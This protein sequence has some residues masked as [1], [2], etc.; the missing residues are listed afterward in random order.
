MR[1]R[2]P[3]DPHIDTPPDLLLIGAS[4]RAL[5]ASVRRSGFRGAL[6]ALDLFGDLDQEALCRSLVPGRD[7][8][9]G[10]NIASLLHAAIALRPRAVMFS[11]GVENHPRLLYRLERRTTILGNSARC[12]RLVRTP[13]RFFGCLDAAGIPHPRVWIESRA[14]RRI[15]DEVRTLA[16]AGG[17]LWKPCLGG[18]G[19]RIRAVA[20]AR[21]VLDT[22]RGGYLQERVDGIPASVSFVA[23]GR[24]C[25]FLGYC[26]GLVGEPGLG[27]GGFLYAG[28]LWGPHAAWLP[29]AARETLARAARHLTRE[30]GLRGLNGI[31]FI[32]AEGRPL[33]L[34]VNPRCTASMELI[35]EGWGRSLF[36]VHRQA[37]LRGRLP[38]LP[39]AED[40][41]VPAPGWLGK[42]I[43]YAGERLRVGDAV[44]FQRAQARDIPRPGSVVEAGWP[45][46]TVLA[47]DAGMEACRRMLLERAA[48][49]RRL[50]AAGALRRRASC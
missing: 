36:A 42:G 29:A 26:Q 12:V 20:T 18:G 11:G 4:T 40:E 47:R 21:G 2:A 31:D 22:P 33:L 35:E 16:R 19:V 27:A 17:L 43:L 44:P 37:C 39:G 46:C 3:A 23:D 45:V 13:A 6:S 50:L 24:R 48:G 1:R 38:A 9:G 25:R 30:F 28:N 15:P 10:R 49:L 7:V 41:G 5:A 32:L 14:G 34:E 8:P